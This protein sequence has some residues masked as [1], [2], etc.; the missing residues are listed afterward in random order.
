MTCHGSPARIK[1]MAPSLDQPPDTFPEWLPKLA[2]REID[3]AFTGCA[4]S[5]PISAMS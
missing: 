1:W 5:Y 3:V 4:A 2:D